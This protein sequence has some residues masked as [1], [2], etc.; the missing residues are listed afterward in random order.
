MAC[1]LV[2]DHGL[3]FLSELANRANSDQLI[4]NRMFLSALPSCKKESE[5]LI[6]RFEV[7]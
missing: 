1:K 5:I 3:H 2:T 7:Y 4:K 6:E